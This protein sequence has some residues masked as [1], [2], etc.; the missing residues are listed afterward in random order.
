MATQ[1]S[2]VRRCS[3]ATTVGV[4]CA[5]GLVAAAVALHHQAKSAR[6]ARAELSE[7]YR[8]ATLAHQQRMHFDLLS[9][10]MDDPDLAAVLDT[11]DPPVSPRVQRQFLFANALYVNTLNLWRTGVMEWEELHG[12]LR[13]IAQNSIFRDYW[14]ATRPH[15]AS[16]LDGSEEAR[17]GQMVD[18]LLQD[19][20][21]S[22]SDEWWVIGEPPA[23]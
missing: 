17:L 11:Y 15:R 2:G 10:A 21:D 19:L 8:Q 6:T 18:R 1:S 14:S 3:A 13:L 12:H 23:E 20:E 9:K 16:L 22:E 7:R 5:A 4:S